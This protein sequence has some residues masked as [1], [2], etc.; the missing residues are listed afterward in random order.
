MPMRLKKRS[1]A[2]PS[3]QKTESSSTSAA[4]PQT[5]SAT[6]PLWSGG[7]GQLATRSLQIILVAIVVIATVFAVQQVTL[8]T[9]PLVLALIFASAFAPAMAW[10]RTHGIPSIAATLIAMLAI[11]GI[12]S[13][14]S[15]L[16]ARAVSNQWGEL[17][18]Q[19]AAG[20]VQLLDWVRTLPFAPTQA[21]LDDWASAVTDFLTS[22]KF[23]SG[24]L[25][26]VSAV[27]NF[28]T[29]FVLMV[30]ILYFFLKDGPQM[31]EFILRPFRGDAYDRAQR[32]GTKTVTVLG[33]YVR[34]TAM[35]ALVDAIGI[36]IGLAI[37]QVPLALPL[38]ILVFFLAFIPIV[39]ATVAGILAA[40][41]ALVTNG[42]QVAFI[43]V[44][45]VVLVNQLEGNFL[46]PVLM[47]R[48]MKLH[49]FVILIALTAGTVLSGILGAILAVPLTAVVWGMVQVWDG[50]DT[51][52]RWARA[53]V[54][55][56][57][58]ENR[59]NSSKK[60]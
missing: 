26:G 19:A 41:V 60:A 53:R 3:P 58:P 13:L 16:V 11:I 12:I 8:V 28:V 55:Q 24:A 56:P 9:I 21:Q 59:K 23:G 30:T 20:F 27:G 43:V 14:I 52:A 18:D 33:A 6:R 17:A 38:S 45:V 4:Q 57:R 36:G 40:L 39:G 49:A 47:G 46:Q 42:I 50:P 34:G 48:S 44:G 15:W 7:F 31:W 29:G 25:A 51:P 10:M 54:R 2:T 5:A 22:A 35:V 32:I 1:P 37:L